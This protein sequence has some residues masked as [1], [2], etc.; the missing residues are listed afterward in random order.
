VLTHASSVVF[1]IAD[2]L[3]AD[4]YILQVHSSNDDR[5]HSFTLH[6]ASNFEDLGCA[7]YREDTHQFNYFPAH[8]FYDECQIDKSGHWLLIKE[9]VDGRDEVDNRIVNLDTGVETV[10]L[11]PDGAGGH[12]D[13]G[14]GVMI[15]AD[16]HHALPN[17]IRLWTFGPGALAPG[18]VVYRD[19]QW[20]PQSVQHLSFANARSAPLDQQYACGS[21]A[22]RIAGP[23]ANEV[24]CVRLDGS[25]STLV[26]APVMTD[27]DATGGGPD[28]Y[29]KDPK[30]NLDPTGQ[31]FMWTSNMMGGR[32]DAFIARVPAQLLVTVDPA[33]DTTA[34]TAAI[35]APAQ[36]GTVIGDVPLSATAADNVGVT[37]LQFKI[38][39]VNLGTEITTAPFAWTW[40]TPSAADGAHTLTAVARDAA[41][42]VTLS[43]PVAVTILNTPAGPQISGLGVVSVTGASVV[44]N[45]TTNQ[46][47]DSWI[48]YGLAVTYGGA[49]ALD[50]TLVS[51]HLQTFAGLTP[52]TTYHYRVTS[53]NGQGIATTSADFSFTTLPSPLITGITVS[54][55]S[56]TSATVSWTTDRTADA[57]MEYGASVAYGNTVY[58]DGSVGTSHA[59]GLSGLAPG[60]TYHFRVR[61][62]TP[63]G[64]ESWSNDFTLTTPFFLISNVAST[65]VTSA[66]AVVSWNTGQAA[67]AQVE[68]GLTTTYGS[69]TALDPA[70]VTAHSQALASLLH[71]STYH[72]RVRSANAS[73]QL[74]TSGDLTF[75]TPAG[76]L[77][78]NVTIFNIQG[79]SAAVNWSTDQPADTQIEYGLTTA[80]GSLTTLNAALVISHGQAVNTGLVPG[81][82]YHVRVRS[83]N[84][85]GLLGTSVDAS[86]TTAPAAVISA[87]S[88]GAVTGTTATITWTTDLPA[89][90]RIEYGL[91]GSYGSSTTLDPALVSAHSHIITGLTP[92]TPYF[93]LVRSITAQNALTKVGGFTVTT[94]TAPVIGGVN[95]AAIAATSATISWTTTQPADSQVD[96]GLTTAYGS[97]TALDVTLVAAHSQPLTGLTAGTLYHYRA[98]SRN[99]SGLLATSA[100]GSFTTAQVPVIS[101]VVVTAVTGSSATIAWTTD[102][103]SN[104]QI[105]Y[106]LT[107]SYGSATALDPALVTAHS[108][109]L[110]GLTPGALYHFRV[111]SRNSAGL[112]ATSADGT[113]TAV[114]GV[115]V[116]NV[117]VSNIQGAAAAINWTTDQPAD[118]QIDYG[119]TTAYGSLTTLN[120][121]LVTG[122]GQAV[123]TGLVPGTTYHIRVRSRNAAGLIGFSTDRTF[124]TAPAPVISAVGVAR[125]TGSS[126]TI[127]WTTDLPSNSRIEYGPTG[128]YGSTTVLDPALVTAHSHTISGLTPGATYFYL[129]RS[130]TAQ[131]ALTKL[132]GFTVTTTTPPV[133]S[134]VASSGVTGTTVAIAW[135]TNQAADSQVEYGPTT[136]YGSTAPDATLVSAHSLTLAGFTPGTFY[137]YRVTSANSAGQTTSSGDFTFT[138]ASAPVISAVGVAA[139]SGS[140]AT[141]VWTTDLPSDSRTEYGLT[142]AYGSTT[143][144]DPALVTAHSQTISGLTPGTTYV[145][146]VRSITGQNAPAQSGGFTFSTV[147][148]PVLSNVAASAVTLTTVTIGWITNQTADSQVDYGPTSAYGSTAVDA[149]LVTTH[150]LT[151]GALTPGTLYHYRV[152]SRNGAGL[153]AASADGTVTTSPG[154]VISAVTISNIQGASAAITW[155]TAQPA[156]TQ[157]EYGRT[158]AYGSLTT[159]NTALVTSH[160]QA[161]NTGLVPGTTYHFRVRSRNAGGVLGTSVDASFTTAPAAVI[162][163]VAVASVTG[164]TATIAWTTDLPANSKIEYGLTGSY[165]SSTT[166]DPALVTAHSHTIT[167]LAPGTTYVFLIR[168][169]TGQN[170]LTKLGGF[171]VTTA[172]APF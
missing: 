112:P 28:D 142:G 118:T 9:D 108:Q 81:T 144:L 114:L 48:E 32:L 66:S 85:I 73:G 159:L 171:T 6:L 170:A 39:G 4:K 124:T 157:I 98:Q 162:S 147:A 30:G 109:T 41:G 89:N 132:G 36:A 122:H 115:T 61:S 51:A 97:T 2:Q 34:P 105:E 107:S 5:V 15:A 123:N 154:V 153:L 102:L 59:R 46:L 72:Y 125:V 20:I 172:P 58:S 35:T 116:S 96:Y 130:I 67:S 64:V 92:G 161:V 22:N 23:R 110:T 8:G 76:V 93:Y 120:P 29:S 87:V 101:A 86:F 16:N 68:Y 90:S 33:A 79:A 40:H 25:M 54:A 106:G 155:L 80:Y 95:A 103:P 75:T 21:A 60:A 17:A 156:D 128:S 139:V 140:S 111:Q 37:G 31:Y 55:I 119:L 113:V 52:N 65:A 14:F 138:T 143:A 136:A 99:G 83:R 47:A 168:S 126:A 27:L 88:V 63:E 42:N 7:T 77:V 166:L 145:Y 56:P 45:W 165:G 152:Q 3:G 151:L 1:N 49:T 150:G 146:L 141:I 117:T 158:T 43:A 11:D 121:A 74:V 44:I 149:A 94:L 13:N 134:N 135:T 18:P 19:P 69:A 163:G 12:S 70:L 26:V 57:S 10:L 104:S 78:S 167:G 71:S 160:G 148:P 129:V 127:A 131:N 50:P 164:T 62:M 100:D 82:T 24:V 84:A 133:V 38:D 169:I 91:S 53:K 137:H